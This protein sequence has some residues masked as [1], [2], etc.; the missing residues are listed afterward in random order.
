MGSG[1]KRN[2]LVHIRKSVWQIEKGRA[3]E[4]AEASLCFF[5]RGKGCECKRRGTASKRILDKI[6]GPNFSFP[7]LKMRGTHFFSLLSLFSFF[8]FLRGSPSYAAGCI[9]GGGGDAVDGTA[10][11]LA[12]IAGVVDVTGNRW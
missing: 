6:N 5:N 12:G 9:N 2:I 10:A 11:V 8:I 3:R 7:F 4:W 1:F